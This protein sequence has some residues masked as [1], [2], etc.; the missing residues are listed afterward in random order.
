MGERCEIATRPER[1]VFG[2]DRRD[3]GVEDV[4]HR[5][6]DERSGTAVAER[7]R[8]GPQEHH[9]SH[10]FVLDGVTHPGGVR[11]DEGGLQRPPP[12][13]WDRHGGERA[14]PGRDAVLR[15]TLGEPLDDGA[16]RGHPLDRRV[17]Q[18][19]R[20]VATGHGDDVVDGDAGS[21]EVDGHVV[22]SS[23]LMRSS[24]SSCPTASANASSNEGRASVPGTDARPSV[25]EAVRRADDRDGDAELADARQGEAHRRDVGF[26]GA[27]AG[28]DDT[29]LGQGGAERGAGQPDVLADPADVADR[30][31]ALRGGDVGAGA[32]VAHREI[33]RLAGLCGEPIEVGLG[34]R[35]EPVEHGAAAQGCGDAQDR[36][37]GGVVAGDVAIDVA[38]GFERAQVSQCRGR[39]QLGGVGRRGQV[40][41]PV[42]EH[43]LEQV[44]DAGDRTGQCGLLDQF[45]RHGRSS[46]RRRGRASVP[47]TDARP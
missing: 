10:D 36:R 42:G 12:V 21:V 27:R 4:D 1:T 38:A 31:A 44:E 9:R 13:G 8:A 14:E 34:G 22:R 7:E 25:G 47:G 43:E 29:R 35:R 40:A 24:R 6:G 33:G 3:A 5:L 23:P 15:L 45:D 16:R 46:S 18:L 17:G 28:R 2:H 37:A 20:F 32:S 39:G 11:A 30:P 26:D 41:P 19:D